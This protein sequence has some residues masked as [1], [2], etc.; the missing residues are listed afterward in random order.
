MNLIKHFVSNIAQWK[1]KSRVSGLRGCIISK[2]GAHSLQGGNAVQQRQ[3]IEVRRITKSLQALFST[4]KQSGS[5]Y[6]AFWPPDT[7]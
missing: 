1:G 6:L 2:N 5:V 7:L 4:G 3:H